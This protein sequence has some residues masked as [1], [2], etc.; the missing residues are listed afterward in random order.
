MRVDRIVRR[1]GIQTF[2]AADGAQAILISQRELPDLLV[3]DL[4]T[5]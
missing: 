1:H 5:A 3:L 4:R 2:H